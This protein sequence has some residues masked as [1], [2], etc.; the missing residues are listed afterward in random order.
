MIN[1]KQRAKLLKYS[2]DIPDVVDVGIAGV[3][4]LIVKNTKDYLSAHELAKVKVQKGCD[5]TPD[6]VAEILSS[7]CKCEV[8]R[9]IGNKIILYKISTRKGVKHLEL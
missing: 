5:L 9:V 1:S 7:E 3:T 8:V 6:K 4:P 2:V